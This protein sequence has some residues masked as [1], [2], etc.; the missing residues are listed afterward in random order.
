MI[1][2]PSILFVAFSVLS[3]CFS[4]DA[5]SQKIDTW[6]TQYEAD[7]RTLDRRFR[8]PLDTEARTYR[9]QMVQGWLTQLADVDF[10]SLDRIG[11]IDYLLLRSELEYQLANDRL[12]WDRDD[13]AAELLPYWRDLLQFCQD[14]ENVNPIDAAQTAEV[15][16]RVAAAA[17]QASAGVETLDPSDSSD[18]ATKKRLD[19]LRAAQ[20]IG[21]LQRCASEANRFYAGYDPEY[22]WWAK[23]PMDRLEKALNTHRAA[24][25]EK[26]VGVPESDQET[27]IGLPIGA[28]GLELELRHEWIA[29]TPEELVELAKREMAWCDNQMEIASRELGFGDDWR[30]AMDHTKSQ[31]VPPGDQPKLIRDLAWEAIRFLQTH[32]LV[33]VPPLAA[34]GWRMTMMSPD[35]QRVNPYFLGGPTIIVSFPTDEMTHQE[36]L[37]SM[38]SNNEHFARATVHHELIPGHHL[39]HYML[40]RHK[41][42]RSVFSTPFWIEGWALYWEMLLWDLDFAQSAEDRVGMLFWRKHR[43]AR[44]IFSLSYHLGTMTPEQCIDYLVERV[45]HERSA[46]TAEVRRSIMGGYS[47]LY[48]AAYML[49]GLQLR[50]LH[51]DLVESGKMTNRDFHDSVLREHSIPIEVLRNY[52]TDVPLQSDMQPSW[53]FDD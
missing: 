2:R 28:E 12:E 16:D 13:A 23:Q 27:I 6:I 39:Q 50:S 8:L 11:Q 30:A 46:A 40:P 15:L 10:Q 52:M 3:L 25:R 42:Y 44:I 49:G 7:V 38:R 22:T 21:D 34:N 33:T 43:C 18:A 20:L 41:P 1:V 9:Q 17:E 26:L 19:G 4:S 36:K 51:R 48:Q 53:R 47:P 24:I 29:H 14:R 5:R 37:M 45:G 32:D 31:H 35:R